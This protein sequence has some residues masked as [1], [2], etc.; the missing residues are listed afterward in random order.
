MLAALDIA[1]IIFHTALIVFNGVGWVFPA[2]R[3]LHLVSIFLTA[4]SWFGLGFWYGWGYCICTDWHWQIRQHL[5]IETISNSYIHYL[6]FKATGLN[7]S[8][9]LVDAVT[10]VLFFAIAATSIRLYLKDKRNVN[11]LTRL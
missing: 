7:L 8:V 6:I 4:F 2:L 10:V 5:G 1:F 3:K 9:L 11:E